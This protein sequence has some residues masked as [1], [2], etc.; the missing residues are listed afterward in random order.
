[1]IHFFCLVEIQSILSISTLWGMYYVAVVC[2]HGK[3]SQK[4]WRPSTT[5]T[6]QVC[7]KD[8]SVDYRLHV[9]AGRL[10]EK[11]VLEYRER[12]WLFLIIQCFQ[13]NVEVSVSMSTSGLLQFLSILVSREGVIH[14]WCIWIK[15]WTCVQPHHHSFLMK[16]LPR[17]IMI[18]LWGNLYGFYRPVSLHQSKSNV[19]EWRKK[20][21][22]AIYFLTFCLR[23]YFYLL[24]QN[25]G[26]KH[27]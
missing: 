21:K 23:P 19:Q 2:M 12:S 6:H 4:V 27:W 24:L 17:G 25:L 9:L 13:I 26:E 3:A 8:T 16:H 5:H 18:L 22:L 20:K 14:V 7:N 11:R 10:I 1:M 15:I